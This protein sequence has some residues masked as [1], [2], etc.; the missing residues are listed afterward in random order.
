MS[1]VLD[2]ILF[3]QHLE[4]DEEVKAVIHKHWISGIKG[5][6]IP[7]TGLIAGWTVFYFSPFTIVFYGVSIWSIAISIWWLRNFFD[8]YLDAWI[9]TDQGIIDL[10]WHGWFHRQSSR[11]LFSDIEGVSY[12]ICGLLG[13]LFRYGTVSIEKISTGSVIALEAVKHPKRIQRLILGNMEEY[14]HGKNLKDST[15][16]QELL[17]DMIAEQVQLKSVE[18]EDEEEEVMTSL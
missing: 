15:Y 3:R 2:A 14:I 9:V 12:E 16:V 13:T 7:I 1:I 18:H 10:E 5:L 8:Y 11:I 17:A 4:D 6:L